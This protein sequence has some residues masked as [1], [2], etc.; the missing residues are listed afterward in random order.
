MMKL[1]K[2]GLFD[3]FFFKG[4]DFNEIEQIEC[5]GKWKFSA[6]AKK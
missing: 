3:V 4:L 2:G 6:F 5:Y 1:T